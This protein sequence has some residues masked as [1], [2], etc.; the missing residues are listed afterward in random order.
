M[1]HLMMHCF[2][3]RFIIM[4]GI[5][6]PRMTFVSQVEIEGISILKDKPVGEVD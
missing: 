3:N 5:N 4:P 2:I 1:M 6:E